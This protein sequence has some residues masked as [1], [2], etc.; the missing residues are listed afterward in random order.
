M[1]SLPRAKTDN[2]KN[3]QSSA[4]MHGYNV[5]LIIAARTPDMCSEYGPMLGNVV[6]SG[7]TCYGFPRKE[8]L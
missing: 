5:R 7:N 4:L 8:Q 3:Q 6:S 2:N 1:Q